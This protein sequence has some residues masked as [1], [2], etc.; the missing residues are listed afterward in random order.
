M[1][2]L[3]RSGHDVTALVRDPEKAER[4]SRPRRATGHRRAVETGLYTAAAE[5][6]DS[7]IHTALDIVESQA[8]GGS[9]GDR[10]AARP[11]PAAAPRG[12]P[13]ASSIPRARWV[14]GDTQGRA[15]EGRRS[16][17]PARRLEARARTG[18]ARR[19]ATGLRTVVI[20][21]GIVYGGARGIIGD[22]LKDG[23][24]GWCGWSATAGTLGVHLRPRPGRPLR[25][26]VARWTS[27]RASST[28]TTRPTSAWTKSSRAIARHA[29]MPPDVRHVP[30][31]EA[32]KKMGPT[33]MRWRSI[34]LSGSPRARALGW[35]PTLHSVAGSVARLLEEFRTAREAA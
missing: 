26:R 21:P 2:A 18:R 24:T 35:A 28:P 33:P 17:P 15:T 4:V 30:I 31:E 13:P 8:E 20:R 7:I 25:A 6:A 29:K 10:H 23:R 11:S 3:V 9:A 5:R 27:A 1:D 34:R 16:I 19:R 14:L 22:L 32:R 12:H